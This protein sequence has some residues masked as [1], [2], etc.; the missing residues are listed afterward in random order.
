[1]ASARSPTW[2]SGGRPRRPPPRRSGS[3]SRGSPTPRS[4]SPTCPRA[5]RGSSSPASWP[6]GP[7][8]WARCAGTSACPTPRTPPS[9]VLVEGPDDYPRRPPGPAPW[10][11]RRLTASA[12]RATGREAGGGGQDGETARDR[13]RDRG[14]GAGG[15]QGRPG[16]RDPGRGA[17]A[18]GRCRGG[19]GGRGRAG[20]G[21]RP[22]VVAL[23]GKGPQR[24][25]RPR[26]AGPAGPPGG[27]GAEALVTGDP[28]DLDEQGLRCVA[29]VRA[30][31]GRVRASTPSWP[32]GCWPGPTWCWTGCSAP[33]ERR[34]QGRGGRGDR[35][36]GDGH[37]PGGRGRHPSGWTG[38]AARSPARR[39]RPPSPSPSRR[40]SPATSWP[41]AAG[42]WAAGG[43]RHRPAPGARPLGVSEAADLAGL[44]PVPTAT[45][46][47]R[48]AGCCC[49]SGAARAWAGRRP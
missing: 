35:G 47:K 16:G 7:T 45:Q 15:R 22:A 25:R 41:R 17:D 21:G 14:R 48:C 1:M 36:C 42:T 40:S 49:W 38:P 28:D 29:L 3:G 2:P 31:G 10:V 39:S 44:V 27:A 5:P 12:A 11:R 23:A 37:R 33:V 9:P 13:V 8:C 6:T 46:H 4:R 24:R 32:D 19:E 30:A 20:R 18:A 34:P 43:G 26:G